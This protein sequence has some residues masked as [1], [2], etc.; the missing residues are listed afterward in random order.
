MELRVCKN[1]RKLFK[2]IYGPELCPDCSKIVSKE[3][4]EPV[5]TEKKYLL[6]PV[7][8]EEEE[9]FEQIKDYI[10]AHPKATIVEISE[11]NDILPTKL[12]EW[13]REDRLAFSDDSA[14]A[15]FTCQKCGAKI[16]SGR[17]CNNCKIS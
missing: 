17:H 6:R 2:Y 11:A 8:R 14:D 12:L 7:L 10:L 1:C 15:W 13:V 16:K 9:K 3:K 5:N 4:E